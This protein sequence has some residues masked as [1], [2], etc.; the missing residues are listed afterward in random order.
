MKIE[1]IKRFS[2]Y[3]DG[4][5]KLIEVSTPDKPYIELSEGI[6]RKKI[7]LGFAK[8]SV[9][10]CVS[11]HPP[12]DKDIGKMV[13]EDCIDILDEK[14]KPKK[15][16]SKKAAKQSNKQNKLLNTDDKEDK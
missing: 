6:A 14:S 10:V 5:M 7:A 12:I 3:L 1:V 8:K 9:P 11:E 13:A 2:I 15:K 16:S 4:G